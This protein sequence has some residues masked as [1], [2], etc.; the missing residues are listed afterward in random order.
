MCRSI[1]ESSVP[2]LN[3]TFLSDRFYKLSSSINTTLLS[4]RITFTKRSLRA[5]S[6]NQTISTNSVQHRILPR[7][8]RKLS[9]RQCNL[10]RI[11]TIFPCIFPMSQRNRMFF[12]VFRAGFRQIKAREEKVNSERK[13]EA[14]Q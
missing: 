12:F 2:K 4:F 6:R 8:P 13:R 7:I 10:H 11:S 1:I 3:S 5:R 14:E 9:H